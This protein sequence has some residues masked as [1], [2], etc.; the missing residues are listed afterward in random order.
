[1]KKDHASFQR[2][3]FLTPIWLTALAAALGLG[4]AIFAVWVFGTAGST[5]VVV[6]RHAEKDV[7]V[8]AA[9][10]PLNEAGEARA[11]LLARM[12]GDAKVL[13]RLD[14][15]YVSP[16]LRNRLTAA[17]LAAHLGIAETVVPSDD[18]AALA[19]RVLHEHPGGRI[20]I[21]GHTDTV[22]QIVAALSGNPKIP[23]IGAAEYGTM[24]IVT[25]PKIGHANL[26]RLN[27]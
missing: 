20:L 11:A 6:I 27:Y 16:A 18:S 25:V 13:G 19:R 2:R 4:F 1:M 10:P 17:P 8:S 21:V 14:A 3:P 5:V 7:S 15:I 22:P 9:D 23:E 24:Y 12:F 26:V